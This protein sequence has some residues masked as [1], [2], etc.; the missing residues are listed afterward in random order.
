MHDTPDCL[1][2]VR[3]EIETVLGREAVVSEVLLAMGDRRLIPT[4]WLNQARHC[5]LTQKWQRATLLHPGAC[6]CQC[7][8]LQ[9]V[10]A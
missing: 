5:S 4:P 3:D 6:T 7:T 8:V 1:L 9:A 2:Q 10:S